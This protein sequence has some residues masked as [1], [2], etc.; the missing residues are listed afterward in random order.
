MRP[1][2]RTVVRCCIG[3]L[4]A[5]IVSASSLAAEAAGIKLEPSVMVGEEYNDN[6]F[7]RR[8]NRVEDF[9]TTVSPNVRFLRNSALWDWDVNAAYFYRHYAR[10]SFND[11]NTWLVNA[12]NRTRL[13]DQYL[14]LDVTDVYNRRSLNSARDYAQESS[15]VN[16][17]DANTLFASP[18]FKLKFTEQTVLMLGY[19]YRNIWYRDSTAA[20][21]QEHFGYIR[22]NQDIS[23]RLTVTSEVLY[24]DQMFDQAGMRSRY[25]REDISVAPK[26][27][28]AD[29]SI[30]AAKI[31]NSW[32]DFGSGK[33]NTQVFW[34][35]SITHRYVAILGSLM[36][37]VSYVPDPLQQ[38]LRLEQYA[39]SIRRDKDRLSLGLSGGMRQYRAIET[40][41]LTQTQYFI[42]AN[43]GYQLTENMRMLLDATVDR[44]NDE[45][46][47]TATTRYLGGMRLEQLLLEKLMISL[48]YRYGK[49]YVPGDYLGS[50]DNNRVMLALK[51]IF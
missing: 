46:S 15:V 31:G 32:W 21:Q 40:K 36:A 1:G 45:L 26:Y 2:A 16:Q 6:V 47:H 51:K 41:D 4:T 43:M 14:F 30:I 11:D 23:S 37:G 39:V 20:D 5:L 27:E 38:V 3:C 49:V 24:D 13:I 34:E 10:G 35:A 22:I 7:L 19:G 8:N 44:I 9:I 42:T 50:Y 25:R 48:D 33:R 28:Y 12:A 18:Y 29:G 17:T